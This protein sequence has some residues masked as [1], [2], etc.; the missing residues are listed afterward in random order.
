MAKLPF[1]QAPSMGLNAFFAFTLCQAMGLT[2]QQ[3]LAVLLVEGIERAHTL[4]S[5]IK[6]FFIRLFVTVYRITY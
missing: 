5:L 4:I 2:W 1:A 6:K 3:A